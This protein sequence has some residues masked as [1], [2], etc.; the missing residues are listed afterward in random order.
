ML[1]RSPGNRVRAAFAAGIL[2]LAAF[3]AG[4]QTNAVSEAAATQK[5]EREG[6]IRNLKL[7]YDAIQ[8]YQM[9][10]KDIPNWLS[11][12]VPQYLND[13]N[14][15]ICP[16]CKRTGEAETSALADPNM[17][18]SYLYEFCP[19]PLNKPQAASGVTRREWK[20]RQMGMV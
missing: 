16:V 9:D 19:S 4:A 20:R 14:V 2:V 3:T 1:I 10:H 6:C 18:C 13:G 8:A 7:I 17:P 11:D 5:A 15:L 12:L